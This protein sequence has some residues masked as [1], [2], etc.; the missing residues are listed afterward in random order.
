MRRVT[1]AVS[2][3]GFGSTDGALYGW[4]MNTI[5]PSGLDPKRRR[6]LYRAT[7]R[8][9]QETDLLLG[10][11][12]AA[13]IWGFSEKELVELEAVLELPDPELTDWLIGR[14][15]IPEAIESTLLRRMRDA[16]RDHA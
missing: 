10:G 16:A 2:E 5:D 11:F 15:P 8:G 13:R 6:L 1:E 12:V 3:G 9:T 4:R 7:H 14:E